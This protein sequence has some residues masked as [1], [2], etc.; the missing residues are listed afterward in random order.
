[1]NVSL[2][3]N[4]ENES[5]RN[6]GQ[7]KT[8]SA[9]SSRETDEVLAV[10]FRK[11]ARERRNNQHGKILGGEILNSGFTIVKGLCAPCFSKG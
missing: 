4:F 6:A 11:N 2:W 8:L 3:R 9:V 7:V 5:L 1:M 10:I